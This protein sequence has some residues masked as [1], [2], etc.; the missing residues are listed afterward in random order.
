MLHALLLVPMVSL[1]GL[2]TGVQTDVTPGI[3]SI[4]L[5]L[6]AAPSGSVSQGEQGTLEGELPADKKSGK[7]AAPQREIWLNDGGAVIQGAPAGLNN[8][9]PRYPFEARIRGWQGTVLV[10]ASVAP[11]GN[12]VSLQ[13][14]RSSG[15]PL[16]D[17][18]ALAALREWQ[19]VPARK[20]GRVVASQVEIPVTFKLDL[21][22]KE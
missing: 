13:V 18:A 4:E 3:S 7:A 15:Y 21:D 9:A 10:R 12:V 20:A 14:N 2:A 5:E 16:L 19:F 17:G 11:S 6:V 1:G 22:R 8:P